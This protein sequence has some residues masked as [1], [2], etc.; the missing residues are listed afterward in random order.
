MAVCIVVVTA[1]SLLGVPSLDHAIRLPLSSLRCHT[2]FR[3]R[4]VLLSS[5]TAQPLVTTQ[6]RAVLA[7]PAVLREDVEVARDKYAALESHRGILIPGEVDAID[8]LLGLLAQTKGSPDLAAEHFEESLAFC[9]KGV[10]APNWP[11]RFATTLTPCSSGTP[12]AT[13]RKQWPCWTSP[14]PS[15]VS[16]AC[17]P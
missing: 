12:M 3:S 7:L 11:G 15:P 10:T 9:R 14:W 16:W 2:C 1:T 17:A 6:A 8:R 13:A 5:P 4:P